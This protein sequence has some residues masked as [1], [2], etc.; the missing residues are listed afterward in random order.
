MLYLALRF[1][2]KPHN[3]FVLF[4]FIS[5]LH[6][7]VLLAHANACPEARILAVFKG[8]SFLETTDKIFH[9]YV[10]DPVVRYCCPRLYCTEQ[11][12][13][14]VLYIP[15]MSMTMFL[16]FFFK[17]KIVHSKLFM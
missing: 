14:I 13:T 4:K 10:E 8:N 12:R 17:I 11:E 6:I 16:D 15:S 2:K 9:G 1:I 7:S 5:K 3:Y